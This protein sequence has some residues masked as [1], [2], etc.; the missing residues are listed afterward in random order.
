MP[1]RRRVTR[2]HL[3]S[4]ELDPE[5]LRDMLDRSARRVIDHLLALPSMPIHGT[6]GSLKLAASLREPIPTEGRSFDALLSQLFGRILPAS[7]NTASPGYLAYIPSGGLPHAAVA[8]LITSAVNRYAGVWIAGP[9]LAS[10]EA[11]VVRWF[12]DLLPFPSPSGGVLTSG[13]SMANLTALVAA[14]RALLPPQF[15]C[16]TIYTSDQAHHSVAKA[17]LIAGFP[18]GNIRTIPSDDHFRMR[19]EILHTTLRQD[20][21]AGKT[22]FLVV[23]SAGTTNTGAIDPLP[24]L[25]ELCQQHGLWLHVDAAYGG[26]FLLTER[27][28]AALRGIEQ[29]RSVTLDPHKGLFLPYGTGCLLVRDQEELRS[30]F[31]VTASYL[32]PEGAYDAA[33]LSP[34]LSREARGLRVWLPL[35]MHGVGPF[36]QQL[37]EKLDLARLAAERLRAI[38]HVELTAPPALSLLAFRLCPP[39][40]DPPRLD[41]LNQRWL[42]AVNASQRVFLSG[43]RAHDRFLLRLCVLSFRTHRDR[44]DEA[45]DLLARSA[46]D[47][48]GSPVLLLEERERLLPGLRVAGYTDG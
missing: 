44:I 11:L 5:Q 47:L 40:L 12:C 38:P 17:A 46:S 42:S 33:D 26:F 39:G 35:K 34:E 9:G 6:A 3:P 45:L 30:A 10:I 37:D 31:R 13:G 8:D 18:P 41:A 2:A 16:G 1:R 25:A 23:A 28:R 43:T 15:L 36:Q 14:R 19:V 22:P 7:L 32:P 20:R 4:L 24:E 29:A 27:G 21:A 48:L